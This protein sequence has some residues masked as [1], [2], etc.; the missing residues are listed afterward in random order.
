MENLNTLLA[1]A[2]EQLGRDRAY[3]VTFSESGPTVSAR[4]DTDTNQL[5]AE[6]W[7]SND[8]IQQKKFY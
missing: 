3:C 5:L 8:V 1:H 6:F 2:I 7:M 4:E